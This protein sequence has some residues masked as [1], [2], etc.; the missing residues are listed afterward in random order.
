MS[1]PADIDVT[2]WVDA[3]RY[4]LMTAKAL[5]RSRRYV[6]VLFMCQQSIVSR[7]SSKRM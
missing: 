6:Y 3:S 7:S 4:D 5:L 2:A 1:E